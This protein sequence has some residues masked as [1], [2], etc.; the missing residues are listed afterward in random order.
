MKTG[1]Q[2]GIGLAAAL[3][4][5]GYL[6]VQDSHRYEK[7]IAAVEQKAAEQRK[8]AANEKMLQDALR[9]L[10]ELKRESERLRREYGAPEIRPRLIAHG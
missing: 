8:A 7:H 6:N 5:L 2:T 1:A 9:R 4:V 10:E 3:A